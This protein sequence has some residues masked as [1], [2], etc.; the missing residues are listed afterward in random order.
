MFSMQ[1]LQAQNESLRT[2]VM[3]LTALRRQDGQAIV[4]ARQAKQLHCHLLAVEK[5]HVAAAQ[6][7][8]QFVA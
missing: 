8:G 6:F 5:A 1:Q 4:T 3:E 2:Q 7:H